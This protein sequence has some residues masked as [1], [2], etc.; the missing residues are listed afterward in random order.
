MSVAGGKLEVFAHGKRAEDAPAAGHQRH[1]QAGHRVGR[2][3]G[4]LLASQGDAAATRGCKA[5]DAAQ[6]GG[7]AGA[8]AAQERNRLAVAHAER[9]ALQDVALAVEGVNAFQLE[10]Q[11][12]LP[13]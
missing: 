4:Y 3:T 8:V 1:A 9:N 7:F 11:A 5:Q 6:G 10:H 12:S 13:R 2:A